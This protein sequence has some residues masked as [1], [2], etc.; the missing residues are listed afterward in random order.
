[1]TTDDSKYFKASNS[2]FIDELGTQDCATLPPSFPIDVRNLLPMRIAVSFTLMEW[3]CVYRELYQE[4]AVG[5]I[6]GAIYRLLKFNEVFLIYRLYSEVVTPAWAFTVDW[7][8]R[9]RGKL[10]ESLIRVVP[11]G[12]DI[13]RANAIFEIRNHP[14]GPY[15][16]RLM[17][18][19]GG[20]TPEDAVRRWTELAV[21]LREQVRNLN[22]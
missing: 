9:R 18:K 14:L 3:T 16:T 11:H 10:T 12:N 5:T 8:L 19:T 2:E 13:E 7:P 6:E 21:A 20:R 15:K 17:L 4:H 22:P 1:M